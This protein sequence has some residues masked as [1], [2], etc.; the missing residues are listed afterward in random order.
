[1]S[2]KVLHESTFLSGKRGARNWMP[3]PPRAIKVPSINAANCEG[4][5][6]IV[7]SRSLASGTS[8]ARAAWRT[9]TGLFHLHDQ[10]HPIGALGPE[11]RIAPENGSACRCS[12]ATAASP[13]IP[14]LKSTGRVAISTLTVRPSRRPQC[15]PTWPA[16]CALRLARAPLRMSPGSTISMAPS[17]GPTLLARCLE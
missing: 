13:S 1:M 10:F 16:A 15:A 5:R 14:L 12:F 8:L 17:V 11:Q 4:V 7:P 6:R 2:L 3:R 9:G